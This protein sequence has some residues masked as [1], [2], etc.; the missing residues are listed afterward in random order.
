MDAVQPQVEGGAPDGAG[1]VEPAVRDG[2]L[3]AEFLPVPAEAEAV[4]VEGF[5]AVGCGYEVGVAAVAAGLAGGG[6][7]GR[8]GSVC[9]FFLRT[10]ELVKQSFK[11]I[12]FWFL[13]RILAVVFNHGL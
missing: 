7:V 2:R 13:N 3:P 1:E 10:D 9:L 4:E 12:F 6:G 5:R 8:R 11:R